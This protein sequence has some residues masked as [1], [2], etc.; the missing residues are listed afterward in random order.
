MCINGVRVPSL[1]GVGG[2]LGPARLGLA[3]GPIKR[4][5]QFTVLC[6]ITAR[7]HILKTMK[8]KRI[9]GAAAFPLPKRDVSVVLKHKVRWIFQSHFEEFVARRVARC[10]AACCALCCA[11][12]A[13]P[14]KTKNH[15]KHIR[16]EIFPEKCC[17]G[18]CVDFFR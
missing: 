16:L 12:V 18:C 13:Q 1:K 6:A 10:C 5:L 11:C 4:H 2:G 14:L 15:P 8:L 17:A 7:K 9:E 3:R